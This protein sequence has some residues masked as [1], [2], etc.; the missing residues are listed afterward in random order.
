MA[1]ARARSE[2]RVLQVLI[3]YLKVVLKYRFC[4][5][6]ISH[7]VE[8]RTCVLKGSMWKLSL[9]NYSAGVGPTILQKSLAFYLMQS[10][11]MAK[12]SCISN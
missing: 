6:T 10:F 2:M 1:I 11:Q 3:I 9:C 7:I 8:A 12:V 5:L 4:Q